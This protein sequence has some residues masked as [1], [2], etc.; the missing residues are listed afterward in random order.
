MMRLPLWVAL[1]LSI[2]A[3]AQQPPAL[4][5][6][7]YTQNSIV[8]AATNRPG[9]LAP[10]S[11]A[12]IYGKGLATAT[13]AA[14]AKE[15]ITGFLPSV[16]P[17]SCTSVFIDNISA[18]LLFVSPGQVNFLVPA[19]LRPGVRVLKVFCDSITG[20]KV[21][22]EL[23]DAVPGLFQSD[24]STVISTH[25]NGELCTV[26]KPARP[27][28]VII[29]YAAGLGQTAPAS[30]TGFLAVKAAGIERQADFQVLLN[31]RPLPKEA[32]LYAG[33]APGFAGLYQINV[34]LPSDFQTPLEIQIRVGEETSPEGLFTPASAIP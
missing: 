7:S 12:T 24:P 10:N 16:Y 23:L 8:H 29:L 17:G 21:E 5:S 31:R 34:R 6:P 18:P 15:L 9:K 30:V 2:T 28:E 22:V 27:G 32:I 14:G 19:N 1:L 25:V 11:I 13:M 26:E 33:V 3:W 20:P 4:N